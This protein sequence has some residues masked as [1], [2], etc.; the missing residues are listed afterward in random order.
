MP[1]KF[2]NFILIALQSNREDLLR[3]RSDVNHPPDKT[4]KVKKKK[5]RKIDFTINHEFKPKHYTIFICIYIY[6]YV[7]VPNT[8]GLW[9]SHGR[10]KVI[11]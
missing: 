10:Y 3:D 9:P 11:R 2:I 8:H 6:I 4:T 7:A 5:K 1:T